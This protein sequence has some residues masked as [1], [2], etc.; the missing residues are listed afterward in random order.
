[1][2]VVAL[3]AIGVVAAGV[4]SADIHVEKVPLHF[5]P[6][7][8]TTTVHGVADD[9]RAIHYSVDVAGTQRMTVNVDG[10]VSF[11]I[12]NPAG[13][14]WAMYMPSPFTTEVTPGTWTIIIPAAQRGE[15]DL[16]V[17]IV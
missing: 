17:T 8:S 6:G 16:T 12:Y 10:P 15:F 13:T 2:L 9:D 1:M 7:T 3:A 4:S 14:K 5:A 11:A